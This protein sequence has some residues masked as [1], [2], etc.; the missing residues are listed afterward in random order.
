MVGIMERI[1]LLSH[2]TY[3]RHLLLLFSLHF[4]FIL[5]FSQGMVQSAEPNNDSDFA[6]SAIVMANGLN[7]REQPDIEGTIVDKL[8]FG[9]R[10]HIVDK[11]EHWSK[12]EYSGREGWVYDSYLKYG[13]EAW[14]S[15][16]ALNMRAEPS[17][18]S[19]VIFQLQQGEKVEI[20]EQEGQWLYVSYGSRYG[21]VFKSLLSMSPVV[22]SA[23]DR[24]RRS[25]FISENPDM[26]KVYKKAIEN[27]NFFIGMNEDQVKASLGEPSEIQKVGGHRSPLEKWVYQFKELLVDSERISPAARMVYLNFRYGY[28]ASWGMEFAGETP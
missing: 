8:E 10:V 27:G 14:V 21:W 26:P 28:L 12:V 22:Y 9:T 3:H 13:D 20:I 19:S 11:A 18:N 16:V 23:E 24:Q 5:L 2:G 15:V 25:K 17:L 6:S 1:T 7:M 4:L